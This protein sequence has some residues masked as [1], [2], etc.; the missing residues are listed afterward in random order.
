LNNGRKLSYARG[1]Q[2]EP[3]RGGGQLVWHSGG[4]AGYSTLAGRLP[5][6]GLSVAIMCNA[7]GSARSA[8]AGRILTLFLPPG[9]IS[10]VNTPA[11]NA[12][13][14]GVAPG[15]LTGK[16][17]LFFDE[18]IGQPL[19]LVVNNN[20][21]A[22]AGGGPLVALA[23]DRFRNQRKSVF[24]M[25]EAEFELRFLSADQIEIKTKDGVTMRYRRGQPFTPTAAEL[26]AFAGRYHSDELMAVFEM[27]AGKNGLMGQANDR[28]GPPFEFK[29]VDRDTFQFAGLILRFVRDKAGKVAGLEY[30]NPIL[31]NVKF[32]RLSN[33]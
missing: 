32:T 24:F 5:K 33:R 2:L 20:T 28:P 11:A 17:G 13:G 26:Q 10:E 25:S 27:T 31:R 9:S 23:A 8:Y 30:S 19:Q 1:L 29:P 22:I 4:A 14:A 6:Q 7:D 12:G 3:F 18:K 16:A 21:L 15:D